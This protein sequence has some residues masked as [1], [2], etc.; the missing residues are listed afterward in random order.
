MIV[1]EGGSREQA[2]AVYFNFVK[3]FYKEDQEP[4]LNS[5]RCLASTGSS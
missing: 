4:Y 3:G 1:H 2:N 5:W